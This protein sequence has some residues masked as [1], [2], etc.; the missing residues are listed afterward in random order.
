[1]NNVENPFAV[2]TDE[3]KNILK[4]AL[5]K[6]F[7]DHQIKVLSLKK[8][9]N[10]SF[11]QL[12]SSLCFSLSKKVN[13]KPID[14]AKIIIDNINP[15]DFFLIKKVSPAGG[16]YINFYLNFKKFSA[17]T[18]ESVLQLD[19][20]YGFLKSNKSL[21]IIVEHTSV[22]PIHPIHVGQARN[23]V[24]GDVLSRMLTYRGHVVSRHYYI[25]DVGRQTAVIAYGY[26]KIG[27]PKIQGKSDHFMGVIYTITSCIV[28]IKR[29]KIN[30]KMAKDKTDNEAINKIKTELDDWISVAYELQEKHPDL[31]EKLKKKIAEDIDPEKEIGILNKSYEMGVDNEAKKLIRK[32]SD[33]S[34]QGFR[35]T[36]KRVKVTYDSWDWESALVWGH[37]VIDVL[38]DLNKTSFVFGL[39]DV[40]EFDA[41]KVVNQLNLKEKLG[42]RTDYEIPSLTLVRGDGTSL[43][44]TRDIA[45]TLWKFARSEMVINVIG[46]EQ[47]LAQLQLK[48]ALYALD[49]EKY[50]DNLIHFAYNLISLPGYKMSSRRGRYVTFDEVIDES[51]ERAYKAVSK[52]SPM[53][54][55]EE[56]LKIA[57]FVGIGAV[58]YALIKVAPS[59]P[60]VFTWDKVLNFETNSAPYLQYTHARA[61]S[62]LKKAKSL[63]KKRIYELLTNKLEHQLILYLASFP[64][65]F[66]GATDFLQPNL[67]ADFANSL[68]DKFNTF[69]NALPVIKAE[70]SELSNVR[71]AL[72]DAVR[73]VLRNALILI[74]IE[75]PRKM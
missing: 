67:I 15:L 22:N 21:Q 74:G 46:I 27:E 47:R 34:L 1:L 39:N 12:S 68:A 51:I 62:L 61:C 33:L 24:L 53:L 66:M 17:L 55:E 28:E 60:V 2:F 57:D 56:K 9:S 6:S 49:Y 19:N 29:L 75:A 3:C 41:N 4:D 72:V 52:H 63:D 13:K 16:G 48:I 35:K 59:K 23:P 65:V 54:P 31:Y 73:I 37:K 26:K 36:L 44:T 18:I 70:S 43:Y 40:L 32:V 30:L 14:L 64:T 7:T 8:T 10:P 11:G 50:A 20:S 25:D 58:R 42:L 69:Y 5:R 38:N 71:I 45:Y